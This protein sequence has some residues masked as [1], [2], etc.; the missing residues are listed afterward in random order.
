MSD[1]SDI[2]INVDGQ[3]HTV[4]CGLCKAK[5][6]FRGKFN[7]NGAKVGCA[8]CDNWDTQDK[9]AK[10]AIDY[11][12]SEMQLALN[13]AMKETVKQSKILSFE[14]K[15]VQNKRHRFII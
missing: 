15:T 9:A 4:L 13:R 3:K 2:V 6:A 1:D 5:V 11:A 10:I 12:V 7:A 8:D 14:G